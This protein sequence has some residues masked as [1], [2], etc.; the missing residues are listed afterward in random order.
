MYVLRTCD[1]SHTV[2]K[3]KC[4]VIISAKQAKVKIGLFHISS[5][6]CTNI[7]QLS[8]YRFLLAISSLIFCWFCMAWRIASYFLLTSS[9]H[10]QKLIDDT[11]RNVNSPALNACPTL[12]PDVVLNLYRELI[13]TYKHTEKIQSS[14]ARLRYNR[15]LCATIRD[16]QPVPHK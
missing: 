5:T 15:N 6:V 4:T 3:C 16:P 2:T 10:T 8:N 13:S 12:P 7:K 11:V 9:A 1:A 14:C